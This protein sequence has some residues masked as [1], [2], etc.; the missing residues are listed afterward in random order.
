[1]IL[2]SRTEYREL[3]ILI[4]RAGFGILFLF[5]GY[6]KLAGGPDSWSKL[7][8]AVIDLGINFIPTFWGF[9]AALSEFGG[10]LLLILG[11]F[12]RFAS[13][14]LLVTMMVAT[15]MHIG[16]GDSFGRYSHALK[17]AIVFLS[18]MLIGSGKYSL[19][20]F[21]IKWKRDKHSHKNIA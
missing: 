21:L 13:F 12:T 7:G 5:H 2:Y 6:P 19:D 16:N 20:E 1:M 3:G 17:A 9:M 11:L 10:G 18:F 4:L 14:F 15:I 8:G